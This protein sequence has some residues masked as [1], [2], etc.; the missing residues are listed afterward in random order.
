MV[1]GAATDFEAVA[2]EI[3]VAAAGQRFFFKN[4]SLRPAFL[5]KVDGLAFFFFLLSKAKGTLGLVSREKEKVEPMLREKLI[6]MPWLV[7]A[8][9]KSKHLMAKEELASSAAVILV[10]F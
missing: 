3:G 7:S 6:S 4:S 5:L 1:S 8:W 10:Y 2:E 9:Q